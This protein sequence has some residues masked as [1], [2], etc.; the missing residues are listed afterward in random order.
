MKLLEDRIRK[1]GKILPGG[2]L[3]VDSFINHQMDISLFNELG[4]ELYSRFKDSGVTKILTIEASGIGVACIAAQYFGVPVLF[5]KKLRTKNISSGVYTAKVESFTHGKT[6]DIMVSKNY[7]NSSDTV[8]IIDDFLALGNA[9]IGLID[10]VKEA[11]A[12]CAG[13]AAIIEKGFQGGGELLK[14]KGVRVESLAVIESMSDDDIVF[15]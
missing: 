7:L 13:V 8:L 15:R 14:N 1:D 6:Y 2:I 9:A 11:G 10:L 4:K 5:A 12:K 3:K